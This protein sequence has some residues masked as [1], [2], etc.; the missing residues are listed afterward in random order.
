MN[1]K[2]IAK[3]YQKEA[4]LALQKWI[5]IPSTYDESTITEGAPFGKGVQKALK[6]FG[7]LGEKNGFHVENIDGYATELSYGEE[8]PLIGIYGHADVVPPGDK[9]KHAPF[10]GVYENGVI[11]GR[12]ATDD[13]G[14]MIAAF[15][16]TKALK[17]LGLIQGFRVKLVAGGD[18]ERG[19]S[20]LRYY[21]EKGHG[22]KPTF[23]FTPDSD[24]PLIYGEKGM[25]GYSLTRVCDLSPI[26]AMDG[27]SVS[28]AVCDSLLVTMKKNIEIEKAVKREGIDAD[29][30]GNEA[31]TMIRFKGKAAHG[32]TPELGKNAA[33]SAFSFLGKECKNIWL[34]KLGNILLSGDGSFWGGRDE[35][36]ELGKASYNYG[37]I[38]YDG[39][40]LKISLDFRFGETADP[41]CLMKKLGEESKMNLVLLNEHKHLLFDKKS[42]L[43]KTLLTSYRFVSGDLFAKPFTIGGG[44]YAKE[45]PNT[46]AFGACFK[47]RDGNMHAPE[48]YLLEK[49][50]MLD[51]AIYMK[52]IL[53]LGKKA[54]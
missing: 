27:G 35:S 48:E 3:R 17:D 24:W 28:N 13:K 43:V 5:Q 16:A 49:D 19:S 52:A 6:F 33:G 46:V 30:L 2:K 47:G 31:L 34:E 1:T 53:S 22:E 44:T 12:G 4:L 50:F 42:P 18:E 40:R 45:A 38:N 20:C 51:I 21:F 23:G 14:P 8:G 11:Y 9:W 29:L 7:T 39:K 36:K 32:S 25:R 10:G 37:V 41:D 15:F 26:V 54:K